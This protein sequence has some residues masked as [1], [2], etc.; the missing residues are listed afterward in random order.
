MTV[1]TTMA[2]EVTPAGI[3]RPAYSDI[4]ETLQAAFQS[5]YGSDAYIAADSKDGQLLAAVAKAIDD[6]NSATVAVYNGFSP[7]TAQGG[8][9]SSNV[10]INGIK[11]NV[12]TNSTVTLRLTGVV[13]TV[14]PADSVVA[15]LNG[16][17]WTV[18]AATVAVTGFVDVTATAEDVGVIDA[19]IGTITQIQTPTRGWQSVTNTTTAAVGA[20]V[21]SDAA[22]RQRQASSVALPSK[23]VLDGIT[24][25]VYALP[26]VTSVR[27][28]ENT[29]DAVDANGLPEHS[30][31]MVVRGGV[32]TAIAD[33]ILRKKTPGAAT[34]GNQSVVRP[35]VNG[36]N[37]TIK[38]S[39]PTV[40]QIV[41][42]ITIKALPGYQVS[43]A[44][45][46]TTSVMTYIN[47]LGS[48]KRVDL[49]RIYVPAQLN[50]GPGSSTFEVDAVQLGAVGGPALAVQDIPIAYDQVAA[51]VS[52]NIAVTVV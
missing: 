11:R 27:A 52:S 18:P 37:M 5:I 44:D 19:P 12:P 14:I 35:D 23:T 2:C 48:G 24:A 21:E 10:K 38:Y 41:V 16:V 29:G 51:A 40:K 42:A 33:A 50:F 1:L 25:A 4:F 30:I 47:S 43:Y 46:I 20:P 34:H 36:V 9:L 26:G 6:V 49:G 22:L 28:Y 3:S 45:D 8:A 15:D 7:A 32:N 13:G 39:I 31:S 17:R